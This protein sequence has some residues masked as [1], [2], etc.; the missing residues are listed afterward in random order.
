MQKTT[1]ELKLKNNRKKVDGR[2][3]PGNVRE[4]WQGLNI[5]MGCATKPTATGCTDPASFAEELNIF[6]SWCNQNKTSES[7]SFSCQVNDQA[8]TVNEKLVT[9]IL[10]R[11]S[12]HKASGPDRLKGRVLKDCALQLGP[13]IT[14]LFQHLLDS[15]CAPNQWKESLIIPIPKKA[16]AKDTKDF[17]PVASCQFCANVWRELCVT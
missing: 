9:S 8:I 10:K 13:V 15:G 5:M 1:H 11:V 7:F 16:R 4:A 6:F 3:T 14:R 12:P 17:R 2:L